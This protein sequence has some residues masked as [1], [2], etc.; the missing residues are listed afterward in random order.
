MTAENL[1]AHTEPGGSLPGYIS[2]NKQAGRFFVA[3]RA[4]GQDYAQEI[5][6]APELLEALAC[7]LMD[8]LEPEQASPK[9]E[10]IV[11][12]GR[13][14]LLG[15]AA[16]QTDKPLSDMAPVTVY[17]AEDGTLWVRETGEFITRFQAVGP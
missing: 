1:F 5:E 7:A 11:K 13:Y 15:H 8:K 2:I 10:H 14:E 16:L 12:G 6:V 3:V 17:R 4:R 9:W